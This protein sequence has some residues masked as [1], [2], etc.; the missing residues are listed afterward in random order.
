[1]YKYEGNNLETGEAWSQV[2]PNIDEAN[3]FAQSS[4][5]KYPIYNIKPVFI[6]GILSTQDNEGEEV[7]NEYDPED[8]LDRMGIDPKSED[9]CREDD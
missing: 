7:D 5:D 2:F 3:T 9:N 1:M 6:D 4:K 8:Y